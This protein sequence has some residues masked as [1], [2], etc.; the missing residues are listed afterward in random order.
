MISPGSHIEDT[1]YSAQ[2]YPTPSDETPD[3]NQRSLRPRPMAF[4]API[5]APVVPSFGAR[6]KRKTIRK[7]S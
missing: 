5:P 2:N 1:I 4:R 3:P 6:K 7:S